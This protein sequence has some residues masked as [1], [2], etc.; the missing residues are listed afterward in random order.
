[1]INPIGPLTPVENQRVFLEVGNSKNIEKMEVVSEI[2][3]RILLPL[4]GS[5]EKALKQIGEGADRRCYL[6]YEGEIPVGVIV[7]KTVL[8][9]EFASF[10]IKNSIEIKTLFVVNSEENSGKGLGTDLVK[11]VIAEAEALKLGHESLH[12][13]VSESKGDSLKFFKK[14]G[15]NVVHSWKGRYK[16][17]VTEYLLSCPRTIKEQREPSYLPTGSQS[18]LIRLI[19]AHDGDIHLLMR[20]SDGN[21]IT[22][23]KDNCV[24]KWNLNGDLVRKVD[25]VEPNYQF[26]SDWITAAKPINQEY[27]V[28]GRRNGAI[29]LWKTNGD[30]VKKIKLNFPRQ[31][32]FSTQELNQKRIMCI[33]KG[34]NPENP[35][36]FVG[37]PTEFEEYN[38]VEGKS[39]ASTVV[40]KTDW[41]YCIHPLSE[42]S[43]L[44]VIGGRI[45]AWKKKVSKWNFSS[46]VLPEGKK[47]TQ[48][49]GKPVR[50]FIT[51][52][53]QLNQ[54]TYALTDF[55]G[56]VKIFD[57][58]SQK[59]VEEW[60]EHQKI[61]WTAEPLSNETF[62]TGGEDGYVK[63]W[64]LRLKNSIRTIGE[65]TDLRQVNALLNPEG[66]LL[67]AGTSIAKVMNE[68]DTSAQLRFYDLKK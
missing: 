14:K 50:P 27:W 48:S 65:P 20:L 45:E 13:T 58:G 10:G 6:L 23:S 67:I 11:K 62:A 30:H 25:D 9:N 60:R 35:T 46:I 7:F 26:E 17:G 4:Y 66:N 47:N 5:Q 8:S 38:L 22:G 68:I 42:D 24:Y 18:C 59:V 28:T 57:L 32:S 36:L 64:D 21:F 49:E 31:P 56:G 51:S 1:M 52:L 37:L 40:D 33:S 2:F 3:Q 55:V 53:K 15:F 39:I 16:E 12:V 61:V 19:N 63:I 54:T 44:V 34:L 43:L 41:P 29:N